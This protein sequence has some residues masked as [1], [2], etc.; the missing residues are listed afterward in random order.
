MMKALMVPETR[1]VHMQDPAILA[2]GTGE[3]GLADQL[4]R[5]F[6]ISRHSDANPSFEPFDTIGNYDANQIPLVATGSLPEITGD[7]VS[8]LRQPPVSD[9]WG[10][11]GVVSYPTPEESFIRKVSGLPNEV[12]L[13]SWKKTEYWYI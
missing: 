10:K 1:P 9:R 8:L 4:D 7:S 2:T 11:V 3:G 12:T 6:A 5:H 13:G